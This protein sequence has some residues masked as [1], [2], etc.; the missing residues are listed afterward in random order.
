MSKEQTRM[1]L[2][3]SPQEEALLDN[4]RREMLQRQEED[5]VGVGAIHDSG[6]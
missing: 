1:G 4:K 2:Q 6:C 3:T 5:L